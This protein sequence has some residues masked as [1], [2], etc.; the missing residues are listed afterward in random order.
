[1][2]L[3]PLQVSFLPYLIYLSQFFSPAYSG[4]KPPQTLTSLCRAVLGLSVPSEA[5]MLPYERLDLVIVTTL[6]GVFVGATTA[7]SVLSDQWFVS[8]VHLISTQLHNSSTFQQPVGYSD[9][10]AGLMG[11]VL[12]LSGI[13]A[14][15][16]TA[17]LLDRFFTH[18]LGIALKIFIPI[19][20]L[21][22][23]SLIWAGRSLLFYLFSTLISF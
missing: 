5:C 1:M 11:A 22:W 14:S 12:L 3:L 19:V 7:F 21:G 13:V 2:P 9:T 18:K 23:F 6:F 8:T 17:P 4:S 16:I 15:I 20:A 10:T